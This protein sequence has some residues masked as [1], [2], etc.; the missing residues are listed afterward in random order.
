M[1]EFRI[2]ERYPDF[3]YQ[4]EGMR[5]GID[6]SGATLMINFNAPT[7]SEIENIQNGDI[8]YKLLYYHDVIWFLFKFGSENWN[9]VPYTIHMAP[10]GVD[11]PE[12]DE[13][14]GLACLLI[15]LDNRNGELKAMRYI[16]F[17]TEFSK[18]FKVCIEAQKEKPFDQLSYNLEL[19]NTMNMYSTNQ[20][21]KMAKVIGKIRR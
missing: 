15:L 5:I 16:S 14:L 4:Q 18:A 7:K 21:V 20:L 3:V 1:R 13:G 17:S 10:E 11:I 8:E 12:I 9:E 2:G 6:N 19:Q